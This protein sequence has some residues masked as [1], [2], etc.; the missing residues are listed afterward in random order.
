MFDLVKA[1]LAAVVG[2]ADRSLAGRQDL[3][4]STSHIEARRAIE[5]Q[6]EA[7]IAQLH[8]VIEAGVGADSEL[9][10]MATATS[11]PAG[12]AAF[13]AGKDGGDT[14]RGFDQAAR[15]VHA[16]DVARRALPAVE[17]QLLDIRADISRIETEMGRARAAVVR[18]HGDVL[19]RKYAEAFRELGGLHDQLVGFARACSLGGYGDDIVLIN[20]P[21][22]APRFNLPSSPAGEVFSPYL[23]HVP[24]AQTIAAAALGWSR[25]GAAL[26]SDPRAEVASFL[27]SDLATE[28]GCHPEHARGLTPQLSRRERNEPSINDALLGGDQRDR[29][30]MIILGSPAK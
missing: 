29:P 18:A 5:K 16:A 25:F 27:S 1:V 21:L 28:V 12:L 2:N 19:A 22:E 30:P 15:L 14:A 9:V 7:N 4:E 6:I 11:G 23:R 17:R 10:T 24:D 8:S 20:Q 13:S 26:A 3:I